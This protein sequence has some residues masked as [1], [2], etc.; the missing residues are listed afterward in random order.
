MKKSILHSLI[1]I[2]AV[3]ALTG[4]VSEKCEKQA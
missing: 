3:G 2:L 4:C 1:A